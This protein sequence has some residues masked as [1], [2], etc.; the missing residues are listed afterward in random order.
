LTLLALAA[1][2]PQRAVESWRVLG[3]MAA[4]GGPSRLQAITPRPSR[5]AI[6][7]RIDDRDYVGDFYR[8]GDKP[9]AALVL[10]PGAVPEGKDDPR[11]VAFAHTLA[12]ARFTVLVPEIS[13]LRDLRIRPTDVTHVADAVRYLIEARQAG[14]VTG[15]IG[16]AAISYAT[17][18][19]ILAAMQPQVREDVRF[20]VAVGGYYDIEAVVTFFTTGGYREGPDHPWR[21]G[22]PNAYGKWLFVRANAERIDN[23]RDRVLLISMA[24]RKLR[25]LDAVIADLT[26][27]L[28]P[29]GRS[30]QALLANTDPQAVPA[31]MAALPPGIRADMAALDVQRH[32]LSRFA[33]R[34][35]LIH[36]RDDAI[37]PYTE[38]LALTAAA[39]PGQA[40]MYLVDNLA[41]VKLGPGG[42]LDG[43]RLWRAVYRLLEERDADP[44]S[45][46]GV[47][48]RQ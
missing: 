27:K 34:L 10:V 22:T 43:L 23:P 29:E 18:P 47:A 24:E 12:R 37:I 11:L 32:D 38:S 9:H 14:H 45:S 5:A 16:I 41:H 28:G 44:V 1:C 6:A 35:I 15:P 36:G 25:H 31:L 7:Y 48:P 2:S 26:D 21:H 17:G 42:I 13:N 8:P 20:L 4:S 39:P 33:A 19:A 30:V 46:R 3:D 40:A